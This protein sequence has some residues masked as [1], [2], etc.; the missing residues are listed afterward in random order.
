M[1]RKKIVVVADFEENYERYS[2]GKV[3]DV[4]KR[5]ADT[6]GCDL[7]VV[8]DDGLM[9]EGDT[10]REAALKIEVQ[11]PGWV[12]HSQ[13]FL[14]SIKDANIIVVTF[15]AVGKQLLD[16]AEKLELLAVMRSGLENI[17]VDACK[18][19]GI[20]VCNAPGRVSEPVADLTC[21]LIL[22][23]NRG[24]TYV[25]KFYKPGREEELLPYFEPSLYRDLTIGIV[26]FGIIGRKILHKLK[27]FDF[28][29]IAYDPFVKQED[30]NDLGV[31]MVSLD[32]LM[33]TADT[34]SIH[35]RLLPETKNMI[36]AREISLMKPTAFFI[37]TARAGLVDEDALVEALENR[38]I[39]GAALDVFKTEPLP[40]DHKL[41]K[42]DN[43][44]LTPHMAGMAGNTFVIS[45]EII[46]SAVDDFL[47]GKP[48]RNRVK[49]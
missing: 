34:V 47:S 46:M 21:A 15:S 14:D 26:G 25:N 24:I 2:K 45:A 16:A 41:R 39:R 1:E 37:N 12:R 13:K 31:K 36:G 9:C 40:D 3:Y 23:I 6:H 19:K 20:I 42:L 43:V 44:I 33:A 27:N 22:D 4:F 10:W 18:E 29:F 35:A 48:I 38:K 5:I 17:D 49:K 8:Y 11:G 7:D 30:V 32:E 28:N